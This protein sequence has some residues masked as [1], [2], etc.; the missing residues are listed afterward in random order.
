M[1]NYD[2]KE[3][4]KSQGH[5]VKDMK[6]MKWVALIPLFANGRN[7]FKDA[8]LE[9]HVEIYVELWSCLPKST[10]QDR[11]GQWC[12]LKQLSHFSFFSFVLAPSSSSLPSRCRYYRVVSPSLTS[13]LPRYPSFHLHARTYTHKRT[14]AHRDSEYCAWIFNLIPKISFAYYSKW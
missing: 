9:I 7:I 12:V 13:L 10:K 14:K 4:M 6:D 1:T 11:V 8:R 5:E 3:L 2:R